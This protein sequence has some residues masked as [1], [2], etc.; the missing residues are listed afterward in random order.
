MRLKP[1]TIERKYFSISYVA[2]ELNVKEFNIRFWMKE[3]GIQVMRATGK[4]RKFLRADIEVLRRIRD[5]SETGYY[6][7]AGIKFKLAEEKEEDINK[8]L[9]A[10]Q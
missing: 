5:L 3:F 1:E 4:R 9:S 8:W 2:R 6:T 10:I 7:L